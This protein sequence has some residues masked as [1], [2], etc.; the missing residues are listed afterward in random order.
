MTQKGKKKLK[1]NRY[2]KNL[3][4]DAFFVYSYD[5]HVIQLNWKTRTAKRLGKWSQTTGT[6]MNYAMRV[7]ETTYD[8]KEIK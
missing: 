1:F 3:R 7:L 6:H 5:T 4:Y 8:V 2:C